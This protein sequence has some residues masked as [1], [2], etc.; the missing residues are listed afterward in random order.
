[1]VFVVQDGAEL[2]EGWGSPADLHSADESPDAQDQDAHHGSGCDEPAQERLMR[3][4]AKRVNQ[5]TAEEKREKLW[6]A[7]HGHLMSCTTSSAYPIV[8]I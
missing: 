6:V 7:A 5:L 2:G 8:W 4:K 3:L 1:M